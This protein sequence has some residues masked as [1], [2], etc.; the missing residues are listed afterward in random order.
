MKMIWS[1]TL[2]VDVEI[3]KGHELGLYIPMENNCWT[4]GDVKYNRI[5]MKDKVSGPFLGNGE[6]EGHSK[7][8]NN[9]VWSWN[10]SI[11]L[12]KS[13]RPKL[14]NI[15]EDYSPALIAVGSFILGWLGHVIYSM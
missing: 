3:P 14:I 12:P 11:E 8:Y 4:G 2:F 15:L 1:N 10:G 13:N 7:E 6:N 5:V 9:R